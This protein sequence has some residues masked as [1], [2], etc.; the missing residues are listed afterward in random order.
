MRREAKLFAPARVERSMRMLLAAGLLLSSQVWAAPTCSLVG[1]AFLEG[2]VV[3]SGQLGRVVE[4][5]RG[6]KLEVFVAA[7]G[8]HQGQRVVF[9]DSGARDRVPFSR[10]GGVEVAWRRVEPRMQH[11]STA[12]PNDSISVYANAVVFGP[13]HGQWIG[14]DR[15]EY[16]ETPI[17]DAQ[18][19]RLELASA[20]P[21]TPPETARGEPWSTLGTMRL[22][23]TVSLGAEHASTP[24]AEDAPAGQ[25]S[26][27]VFRYSLRADDSFLGWLS[28]FFNVPY[29][30]GSAGKGP[31][32]Q[33]ERYIGADCADVLVA[34][35]RRTGRR[36]LEYS[37]VQD[38]ART[39]TRVSG[40]ALVG[41]KDKP[42]SSL[43]V[44]KDVQPGDFL[45]LDYVNATELPRAFDHIVA[46]VEDRGPGG[47]ADGLLGPEDLVA[48]SGDASGLK[49]EALSRQGLVRITVLRPPPPRGR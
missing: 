47:P 7:P 1:P 12:A 43:R 5:R 35:L 48:D 3:G 4:A 15:L 36:D 32:S 31:K 8:R 29:L 22:A 37:S 39:M 11:T 16:F 30:F 42:I 34:A 14:F 13:H 10:C 38:M 45:A 9:G 20:A 27:R 41:D 6:D 44:G 33:A 17:E 23:A 46:F 49:L 21:T 26:D 40:P 25:I 18:A 2:R 24:G 19:T 28:S